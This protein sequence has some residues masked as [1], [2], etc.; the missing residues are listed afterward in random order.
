MK[1]Q[2]AR[3]ER[4][5]KAPDPGIAAVL[6]FGPDEGLVR[7]RTD[8]LIRTV[9]D[10]PDDPFRMSDFLADQLRGEPAR[11]ADEARSLSLIGGRRVV[12]VRQ[13]GDAV[14]VACRNLLELEDFEAWVVIEAGDLPGGSSLRKLFE[15]AKRAAA[16]PCYRDLAR[17]LSAL[18]QATLRDHGLEAEPDALS[19]LIDHLGADRGL[20]RA[21]LDKLVL[22]MTGAPG[23]AAPGRRRVTLADAAAVIGDTSALGLDDLVDAAATGDLVQVQ[24]CLDRLLGEGQNPVRLV[25]SLANHLVRINRLGLEVEAGATVERVVDGARPQIHFR[26]RDRVKQALRRW[27][28]GAAAAAL[29]LLVDAE[30]KCKST[31]LPAELICR[32]TLLRIGRAARAG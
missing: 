27:R 19:Y 23:E 28:P 9:L 11:L 20:T 25:R 24:R 18:I 17:D 10:Q 30:I 8:R 13:A 7:E 26:R 31:G 15:G 22:Y 12:R 3:V 21:E 6:V 1:L 4:F 14:T 2:G 5:L 32:D 16:L 29:E